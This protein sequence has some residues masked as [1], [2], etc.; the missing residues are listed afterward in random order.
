VKQSGDQLPPEIVQPVLRHGSRLG[1]VEVHAQRRAQHLEP[2]DLGPG[3][4]TVRVQADEERS[5]RS[6][7]RQADGE[8]RDESARPELLRHFNQADT[9]VEPFVGI[10]R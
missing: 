10:V 7:R 9:P 2:L 6:P 3:E 1:I 4:P 8:Q 5:S